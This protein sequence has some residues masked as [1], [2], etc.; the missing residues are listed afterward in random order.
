MTSL[1]DTDFMPM[2]LGKVVAVD[3]ED[4]PSFCV[5]LKGVADDTRLPVWIRDTE[6]FYWC[7]RPSW[8]P[9]SCWPTRMP[10]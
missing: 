7:L 9:A 4:G 10:G 2:R 3:T 8:S 5:V 6:G 1:T